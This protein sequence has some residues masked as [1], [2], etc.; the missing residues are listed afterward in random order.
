MPRENDLTVHFEYMA[1]ALFVAYKAMVFN[2]TPVACIFTENTTGEVLAIGYNDTNRSLNGTRH[3]EFMA[4][5]HIM[6]THLQEH[7][8]GSPEAVR[9]LFANITLYVTVEPCI[10]CA[11]ALKQIGI[12][13]V[14]YG[15]GNDRFGG[16][17]T[18]LS[19]HQD[20][21]PPDSYASYGGVLR[22]E[23]VQ[24]LRNFYVQENDSAPVPQIKKNRELAG[25]EYPPPFTKA[26]NPQDAIAFFGEKRWNRIANE[27]EGREVTPIEGK[28]YSLRELM[29]KVEWPSCIS[30][31]YARENN[32][33]W[34]E[35][36]PGDLDHFYRLFYDVSGNGAVDFSKDITTI[37]S[38]PAKR[39]KVDQ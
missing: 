24:L 6:N 32:H 11:S 14:V 18:V 28:G 19:I 23:A 30:E 39:I 2:E 10:M 17:G 38:T 9:K 34:Q 13:K 36:L 12:G 4:M 26:M 33:R 16:N 27:N 35:S 31:V 7:E 5:E 22:T 20:S 3:A 1:M 15:C 8:R 29:H 21:I 37:D 25:K